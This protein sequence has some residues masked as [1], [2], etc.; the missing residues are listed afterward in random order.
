MGLKKTNGAPFAMYRAP[1]NL[2]LNSTTPTHELLTLSQHRASGHCTFE[3]GVMSWFIPQ[4]SM[5]FQSLISTSDASTHLRCV[6]INLR[7]NWVIGL[8]L[9]FSYRLSYVPIILLYFILSILHVHISIP[10]LHP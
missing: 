6:R 10:N 8:L 4:S 5:S 3:G 7:P 9:I 1:S 2:L